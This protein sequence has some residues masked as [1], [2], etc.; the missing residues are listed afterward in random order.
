MARRTLRRGQ[1]R[2]YVHRDVEADPRPSTT[3]SSEVELDGKD[4]MGRLE[5]LVKDYDR[6]DITKIDW[7]D[8]LAFR[9]IEKLHAEEASKSEHLFLY[10]ELP[11]F[12]FPVVFTEQESPVPMPPQPK[13]PPPSAGN[14]NISAL[15]PDMLATDTHLWRTYDPDSWR[16]EH[17]LQVKQKKLAR[18]ERLS[19]EGKDL[20]PDPSE[21]D[22][23]NVSA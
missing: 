15:P 9:Q 10:V 20:K 22:R 4:E 5:T 1:Q 3:T 17:P 12:D 13:L 19:E 14:Q 11:K 21:R 16:E 6:G 2:L 7:L 23:L 18:S 8:R